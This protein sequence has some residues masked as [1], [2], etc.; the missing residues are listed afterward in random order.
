MAALRQATLLEAAESAGG[1][2]GPGGHT[3]AA[4]GTAPGRARNRAASYIAR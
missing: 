2:N 4:G 1:R 3:P